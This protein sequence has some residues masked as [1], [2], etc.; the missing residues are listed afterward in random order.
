MV[1]NPGD[2]NA[3]VRDA[4]GG[5]SAEPLLLVA[6]APGAS[7]ARNRGWREARGPVVLFL[8]DDILAGPTLLAEH[9][10]WHRG[11]P[12]EL[13][14]VLGHVRWAREL[15]VTPFMRWLDRGLQFDYGA[16]EGRGA[17]PGH[18]YTANV[19][20]KRTLLERSGGFDEGLPYLFEDIELGRRLSELGFRL[21]YNRRAEAEHLHEAT[22]DS[23]KARMRTAGRAEH[24]FLRRHP[25]AEPLLYE[26]MSRAAADP[27][28]RG[29]AAR[30][31][32]LIPPWVPVLG[33]I[34]WK[35]AEQRWLQQLA[36]DFLEAW[37]EAERETGAAD[38]VPK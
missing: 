1:A 3:A 31:A 2:D 18:L 14:G 35:S 19:S 32:G 23:W 12:D 25:D 26:Q 34:V 37:A 5:R 6:S 17:D 27:P 16:I 4:V 38:R 36:P 21:L 7:A 11:D 33:P 22:P 9:V 13:V 10:S 8:G 24:Q 20:L 29:R 28:A 15:E 30:L